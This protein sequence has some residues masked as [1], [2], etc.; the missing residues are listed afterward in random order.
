M[1]PAACVV[2]I[3]DCCC[4]SRYPQLQ[5]YAQLMEGTVLFLGC[6]LDA[7]SGCVCVCVCF[8]VSLGV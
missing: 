8:S 6:K 7:P 3:Y 4:W 1:T 2:T 5:R